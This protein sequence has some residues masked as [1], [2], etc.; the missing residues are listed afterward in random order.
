MGRTYHKIYLQAIFA[1]KYRRAMIRKEWSEELFRVIG[2]LINEAGAQSMIVNGV[3]DHV[4]CLIFLPASVSVSEVMKVAKAK[5][6]RW[7]N[8]R[9]LTEERFEWQTGFAVF[10]YHIEQ[11]DRVR[12]YIARQESHHGS[13]SFPQE[14]RSLLKEH[15]VPD[16]EAAIFSE[17]A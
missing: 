11:V 17:P 2:N 13:R 12:A 4:H 9:R 3:C 7:I 1:V 8:A 16:D 14:C 10:S 15:R 5:S 6:S